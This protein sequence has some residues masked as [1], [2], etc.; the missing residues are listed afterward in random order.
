MPI[1]TRY[2]CLPSPRDQFTGRLGGKYNFFGGLLKLRGDKPYVEK[3]MA[4][5]VRDYKCR[6]LTESEVDHGERDLQAPAEQPDEEPALR[7]RVQQSGEGTPAEDAT[8]GG[9]DDH[10]GQGDQRVLPEGNRH[11][12]PRLDRIRKALGRLDRGK[13]AHWT[14]TGLPKVAAV[15]KLAR[16]ADLT[17]ADIDKAA[18]G[19]TREV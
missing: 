3:V 13:D 6:I 16:L 7:G 19:F 17:R 4:T 14:G 18:P 11:P 12:N 15:A 8:D 2:A 10:A 9:G 5:L 1:V